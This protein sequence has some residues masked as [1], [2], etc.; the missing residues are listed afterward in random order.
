[1]PDM[2]YAESPA[3]P[4]VSVREV[5]AASAGEAV[6]ISHEE[7]AGQQSVDTGEAGHT[8]TGSVIGVLGH[9]DEEP[10]LTVNQAL[11]EAALLLLGASYQEGDDGT[12]GVQTIKDLD[13]AIDLAADVAYALKK[14]QEEVQ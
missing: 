2:R 13:A 1:M 9:T 7:I 5:R 10:N 12:G 14:E 11:R 4:V 6:D 3:W 8:A